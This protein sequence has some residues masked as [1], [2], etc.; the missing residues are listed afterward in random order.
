[1][2]KAQQ[3]KVLVAIAGM[4]SHIAWMVEEPIYRVSLIGLFSVTWFIGWNYE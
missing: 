4:L 2:T 1:M 3:G